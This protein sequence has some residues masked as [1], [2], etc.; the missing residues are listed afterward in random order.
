M[1]LVRI[2]DR[3]AQMVVWS[4]R[5][6][7]IGENCALQYLAMLTEAFKDINRMETP[8]KGEKD[9]L[10]YGLSVSQC[11]YDMDGQYINCPWPSCRQRFRNKI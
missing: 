1:Q 8:G 7:G 6:V 11:V 10:L 2:V 4:K 3:D 5:R 9:V